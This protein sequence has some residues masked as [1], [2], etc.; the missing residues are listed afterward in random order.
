[1]AK[2][3]Q[4]AVENPGG[5]EA[6]IK[7]K[8]KK[9]RHSKGSAETSRLHPSSK[10]TSPVKATNIPKAK[11]AKPRTIQ[12]AGDHAAR[13]RKE[14]AEKRKSLPKDAISEAATDSEK[15]P[16]T[17]VAAPLT[18]KEVPVQDA[19]ASAPTIGPSRVP[20]GALPSGKQWI[21][22]TEDEIARL[23][24]ER[25]QLRKEKRRSKARLERTDGLSNALP[26]T[27]V[28]G[29]DETS[30][31]KL[32]STTPV[33]DLKAEAARR[34]AERKQR[35]KERRSLA[36]NVNHQPRSLSPL[37]QS[38]VE[39]LDRTGANYSPGEV[40]SENAP[41]AV[42]A[43]QSAGLK[44]TRKQRKAAAEDAKHQLRSPSPLTQAEVEELEKT[45]ADLSRD[46][47]DP[48]D[49]SPTSAT[50][51][52]ARRKERKKK[53]RK[54]RAREGDKTPASAAM[55]IDGHQSTNHSGAIPNN[56]DPLTPLLGSKELLEA[57]SG[58]HENNS[59][60][61]DN[62]KLSKR[63]RKRKQAKERAR[64]LE[65][66]DTKN[67]PFANQA[68]SAE[69]IEVEAE[70]LETPKTAPKKLPDALTTVSSTSLLTAPEKSWA[71]SSPISMDVEEGG[72]DL[73][74]KFDS[75]NRL[76]NRS[77]QHERGHETTKPRT[78][79][80][81][82]NNAA[83]NS[84]AL[85][86]P[87]DTGA[88]FAALKAPVFG[89]H[90]ESLSGNP[91]LVS[92]R[93][94]AVPT[95]NDSK[96]MA[97]TWKKISAFYGSDSE[98]SS[99]SSEDEK[100]RK[101]ASVA[102][103][104]APQTIGDN[105]ESQAGEGA[106]DVGAHNDALGRDLRADQAKLSVGE[107]TDIAK[108]ADRT[109]S[110]EARA[111]QDKSDEES[112]DI[113]M[114]D[115]ALS[116][117]DS[118]GSEAESA[119]HE[120]DAATSA[121]EQ[122][123]DEIAP[124][125]V[126]SHLSPTSVEASDL[127]SKTNT[128]LFGLDDSQGNN[129][130]ARVN[131]PDEDDKELDDSLNDVSKGVFE[132]TRE[133][134][135]S[136]PQTPCEAPAKP[137]RAVEHEKLIQTPHSDHLDSSIRDERRTKRRSLFGSLIRDSS[138]VV[139]ISSPTVMMLRDIEYSGSPPK[140]QERS[141][142]PLSDLGKTPSPPRA[143]R[144]ASLD[145][146]VSKPTEAAGSASPHE[147]AGTPAAQ[148]K[149]KRK[150]TGAT[151][152]HFSTRMKKSILRPRPV[153]PESGPSAA[154]IALEDEL[155][156]QSAALDHDHLHLSWQKDGTPK[157]RSKGRGLVVAK[158]EEAQ[159][160]SASEYAG[161]ENERP[162]K[163]R[164]RRPAA[165]GTGKT[166]QYFTPSK[167]VRREDD[168]ASPT[169]LSSKRKARVPAGTSTSV[170]P[171]I[172]D[173]RFGLIQEKLFLEPFWLLIAVT[174]LNKTGGKAAAPVF[175]QLK[176]D[177]PTPAALADASQKDLLDRVRHLGL[178]TQR[179][180]R[181]IAM[182]KAWLDAGPVVGVRYRTLHYPAAGN[183]KEFSKHDAI[184]GDVE[185]CIGAIE[186]GKVPGCGP[187]AWDSWRIFCRDVLRGVAEDYNGKG[188]EP[189]FEPE[190]KRVLPL[191]KELRACLRWMWMR[192]GFAWDPLT[193]KRRD[194]TAEELD[195]AMHGQMRDLQAEVGV[196]G[197]VNPSEGAAETDGG[198]GGMVRGTG[199]D[200]GADGDERDALDQEVMKGEIDVRQEK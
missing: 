32:T 48:G 64:Q 166:S 102:P 112:G 144:S 58:Q 135:P 170:V 25:K 85:R 12:S 178:Q 122:Q 56:D 77:P 137:P 42:D 150:M 26:S 111:N 7:A 145:S 65:E 52:A 165:K 182:A 119:G 180:N 75:P 125:I 133:L 177:Y 123:A 105:A 62:E 90:R 81:A 46:E 73:V 36:E 198:Q 190:W 129:K 66:I 152:K 110:K 162:A 175:W 49:A 168:T 147:H 15:T 169:P 142:S 54:S 171:P 164:S 4:D 157:G 138:P 103:Q 5:L 28:D 126:P 173:E 60:S 153:R 183:G 113:P 51:L 92:K 23:K 116:S 109:A 30:D 68:S 27:E 22:A 100:N 159:S 186:I 76:T 43:Q 193:G 19:V 86:T 95:F 55:S 34:K 128:S 106:L 8:N 78:Q 24:A 45:G 118:D 57:D 9:P 140:P 179:S 185:E 191:D 84:K 189:G 89:S 70:A 47:V 156:G 79:T 151:S 184:E 131:A 141:S 61:N 3:K 155:A 99:E 187:Y 101:G 158:E 134:P 53:S 195:N 136:K 10:T 154:E 188:T 83:K 176:A 174:F 29:K 67:N 97:E 16:W 132:A 194:A 96:N 93:A 108:T 80:V 124:P 35:K 139:M 104:S 69:P 20:S 41:T 196:E 163:R 120:C 121:Q 74:A 172:S 160:P 197:E 115:S 63:Q 114:K 33:A 11:R 98:S 94:T 50:D 130:P 31:S 38:E 107:L 181:L 127:P 200:G 82:P 59:A 18:T 44:K 14:Q 21:L 199:G 6:N 37:N 146:D 117:G 192:E 88:A 149:K 148:L 143:S 1:M 87:S 17:E 72:V 39:E 167:T 71:E 91:S 13:R 2:R 40:G 161:S